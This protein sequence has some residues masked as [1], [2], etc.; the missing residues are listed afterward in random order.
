M[1]HLNITRYNVI[2]QNITQQNNIYQALF[3]CVK[4]RPMPF[5]LTKTFIVFVSYLLDKFLQ[6]FMKELKNTLSLRPIC[7]L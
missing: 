6:L 3:D 5:F 2:R 1:L 4:V 7:S